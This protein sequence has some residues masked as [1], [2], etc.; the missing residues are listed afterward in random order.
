MATVTNT[1]PLIGG[2]GDYAGKTY[3]GSFIP[4]IW[5]AK[6]LDALYEETF[7]SEITNTDYEGEIK[8]YGDSVRIVKEP[9][10]AVHQYALGTGLVNHI[11]TPDS[12]DLNINRAVAFSVPVADVLKAQSKPNLVSLYST[13]AARAMKE[14]V[15]DDV[16]IGHTGETVNS[17]AL[18]GK[19]GVWNDVDA[20]NQGAAAGVKSGALSLGTA[21]VPVTLTAANIVQVFLALSS[22]L[23]EQNVP[24]TERYLLIDTATRML[25]LQSPLADAGFSGD[26]KT[27][28]R[29]GEIGVFDRFRIFVTNALPSAAAGK[30]YLGAT[31]A[32]AVA[33]RTILAGHKSAISFAG[34]IHD[35]GTIPNPTDFGDI[36]RGYQVFGY[37]TLRPEALALARVA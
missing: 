30:D 34:Q 19:T 29:T 23:D 35:T 15:Q 32:G 26:P 28:Q 7:L 13:A 36:L 6:I 1:V 10:V 5:S 27:M 25:F 17:Y 18:A 16:L 31:A 8:A 22:A 33:H 14:W 9:S 3:S 2:V 37:K 24:S 21:A 4:T 12:V 20:S 11:V